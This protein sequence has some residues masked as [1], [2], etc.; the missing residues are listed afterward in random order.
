MKDYKVFLSPLAIFKLDNILAFIEVEWGKNAKNKFLDKLNKS[1]EQLSKFPQSYP[2]SQIKKTVR[3]SV[4][5]SQ[6]S[7]YYRVRND[8]VEIITVIDN[9]QDPESIAKEIKA[10]FQ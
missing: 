5:T 2:Q 4:I 3:K 6:T 8:A 9:R 7:L 1:V 10:Y